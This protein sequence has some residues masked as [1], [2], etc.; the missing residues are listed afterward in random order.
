MIIYMLCHKK[1]DTASNPID[2]LWNGNG[3]RK[4]V[5]SDMFSRV[6]NIR[7]NV[8][9]YSSEFEVFFNKCFKINPI[10]A[11]R[12]VTLMGTVK[13]NYALCLHT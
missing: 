4:I 1:Y 13:E 11:K 3:G 6:T 7:A 12:Y 2:S 5:N 9:K 8:Q 10:Q